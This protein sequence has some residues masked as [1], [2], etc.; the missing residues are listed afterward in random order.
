MKS[1]RLPKI[2]SPPHEPSGIPP[3]VEGR[4]MHVVLAAC[5]LANFIDGLDVMAIAFAGPTLVHEWGLEP[6]GLGFLFSAG[7]AGVT[8]GSLILSPLTD[9]FGRRPL[10]IMCLSMMSIAMFGSGMAPG[11]HV[12]LQCGS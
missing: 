6:T 1:A 7:L 10:T 9:R 5:V 2:N 11:L 12:L 3:I 8:L 4:L